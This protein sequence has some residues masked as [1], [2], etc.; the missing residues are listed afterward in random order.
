M[1]PKKKA[2]RPAAFVDDLA[3]GEDLGDGEGDEMEEEALAAGDRDME[4]EEWI[5]DDLGDDDLMGRLDEPMPR[6]LNA[7]GEWVKGVASPGAGAI[8]SYA[9]PYCEPF[10]LKTRWD[11]R[12]TEVDAVSSSKGQAPF[13]PGAT[14]FKDRK[15]YLGPCLSSL[16]GVLKH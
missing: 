12:S 3:S 5:D 4:R 13:Q 1:Q 7:A 10:L 11:C 14:P 8:E 15:R 16:V 2:S 9:S 6:K